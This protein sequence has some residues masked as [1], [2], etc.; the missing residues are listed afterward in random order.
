MT[1]QLDILGTVYEM[2][3]D[4][5]IDATDKFLIQDLNEISVMVEHRAS[6]VASPVE[7]ALPETK[8]LTLLEHRIEQILNKYQVEGVEEVISVMNLV[9][10]RKMALNGHF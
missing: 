8:Y 10:F 2:A 4:L 5:I 3:N 1:N 7:P 9:T 6:I